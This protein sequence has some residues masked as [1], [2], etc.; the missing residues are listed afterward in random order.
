M[1]DDLKRE[2]AFDQYIIFLLGLGFSKTDVASL[3]QISNQSIYNAIK[4]NEDK[5]I[6]WGVDVPSSGVVE[7]NEQPI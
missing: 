5:L 1:L 3:C 7:D 2:I 4:R 6:A